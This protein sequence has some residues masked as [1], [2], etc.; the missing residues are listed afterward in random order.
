M[1]VAPRPKNRVARAPA[2]TSAYPSPSATNCG[3]ANRPSCPPPALN[4]GSV[5][6]GAPARGPPVTHGGPQR[7]IMH[8]STPPTHPPPS[9]RARARESDLGVRCGHRNARGRFR[10]PLEERVTVRRVCNTAAD[11]SP[12]RPATPARSR[13][14]AHPELPCGLTRRAAPTQPQRPQRSRHSNTNGIGIV[15]RPTHHAQRRGQPGR[16][17]RVRLGPGPRW[18]APD[19]PGERTTASSRD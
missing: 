13:P 17:R 6:H 7:V 11:R 16:S 2:H 18:A 9:S 10:F 14:V 1:C 4:P 15:D 8:A 19:R 5:A 3:A 12:C